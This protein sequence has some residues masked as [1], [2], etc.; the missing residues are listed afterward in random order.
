MTT[1]RAIGVVGIADTLAEAEKIAEK[2]VAAISGP[3]AHRPD[4]GTADLIDK[5]IQHMRRIRG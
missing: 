4:I 3:V 1:S 5:R 2:A